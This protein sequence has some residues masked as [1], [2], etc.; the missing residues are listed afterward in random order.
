MSKPIII[1]TGPAR[2]YTSMVTKFLLNNGA[3]T[4][5]KSF[6]S[7]GTREDDRYEYHE[8]LFLV[9]LFLNKL[10]RFKQPHKESIEAYLDMFPDDKVTVFKMPMIIYFIKQ[11]QKLTKREIRVLYV[12]RNPADVIMST[13]DKNKRINFMQ[14]FDRYCGCYDMCIGLECNTY[15][16]MAERINYESKRI[17]TW[18][19]LNSKK[20][21]YADINIKKRETF[22]KFKIRNSIWKRI[23]KLLRII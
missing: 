7:D 14:A 6:T 19:G 11:L 15:I 4:G 21:N 18:A 12:L 2:S 13:I 22:F 5:M 17:L 16:L 3:I 1:V 8:D 10:T 9:R 23:F 20:I